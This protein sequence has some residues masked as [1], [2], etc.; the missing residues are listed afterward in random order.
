MGKG[1]FLEAAYLG[2]IPNYT[3]PVYAIRVT[4]PEQLISRSKRAFCAVTV[5]IITVCTALEQLSSVMR[6]SKK[7]PLPMAG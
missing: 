1:P 6:P 3:A 2:V 4:V 7:G 5:Q